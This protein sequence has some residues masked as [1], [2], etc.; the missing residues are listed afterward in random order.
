MAGRSGYCTV[1]YSDGMREALQLSLEQISYYDHLA[2]SSTSRP[3]VHAYRI[4]NIRGAQYHVLSRIADAGLDFTRRTNFIAHHLAFQS[5]ELPASDA[6]EALTPP[7]I[8]LY[9]D[10]WR[11]EWSQ[12]PRL[13]KNEQW[14][15]LFTLGSNTCN[16]AREWKE[17]TDDAANGLAP[18][19]STDREYFLSDEL[20]SK[21]ILKL[22]A[23]TSALAVARPGGGGPWQ[24]TFS[25]FLQERDVPSDFRWRVV[26][27]KSPAY[28]RLVARDALIKPLKSLRPNSPDPL[29]VA[30]ARSGPQPLRITGQPEDKKLTAR[31][32]LILQVKCEGVP[33]PK[34]YQWYSCTRTGSRQ[35]LRDAQGPGLQ[36]EKPPGGVSRYQVVITDAQGKSVESR[37]AV[38]ETELDRTPVQGG[39]PRKL[40]LSQRGASPVETGDDAV[41]VRPKQLVEVDDEEESPDAF[42]LEEEEGSPGNRWL[43]TAIGV[44]LVIFLAL[45][46]F[47]VKGFFP[48]PSHST[49]PAPAAVSATNSPDGNATNQAPQNATQKPPDK[50]ASSQPT[51]PPPIVLQKSNPKVALIIL[52]AGL[53]TDSIDALKN[54]MKVIS[55]D[56]QN[57]D[58]HLA[59]LKNDLE[60]EKEKKGKDYNTDRVKGLA[61]Q[62]SDIKLHLQEYR[63]Q[64]YNLKGQLSRLTRRYDEQK[65]YADEELKNRLGG[66]FDFIL[67]Q[68]LYMQAGELT[69]LQPF[70]SSSA[71]ALDLPGDHFHFQLT[72]TTNDLYG[73]EGVVPLKNKLAEPFLMTLAITNSQD[74]AAAARLLILPG[75]NTP[76]NATWNINGEIN[77]A[78]SKFM[79]ELANFNGVGKYDLNCE[80]YCANGVG[81]GVVAFTNFPFVPGQD[82]WFAGLAEKVA[83]W[84]QA[85]IAV[86][87]IMALNKEAVSAP[88]TN[89]WD[90]LDLIC[91]NLTKV[92]LPYRFKENPENAREQVLLDAPK[93]RAE[94]IQSALSSENVKSLKI[95]LAEEPNLPSLNAAKRQLQFFLPNG[96]NLD[97]ALLSGRIVRKDNGQQLARLVLNKN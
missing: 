5:H 61:N 6:S 24:Q 67:G 42:Q 85:V 38:V 16:P 87:A 10:G 34:L 15:N 48:A 41:K 89:V 91:Q 90:D 96:S 69:R 56:I 23:E 40:T 65:S 94:E 30:Y 21:Q 64:E 17:V 55:T 59:Q 32:P 33:P 39:S 7:L 86:T 72:A 29:A 1:A 35:I 44:F 79:E 25:T 54:Q 51:T 31:Q 71:G 80:F 58:D 2:G 22:F 36:L 78:K 81:Q 92:P 60:T 83:H 20:D 75:T 62:I 13:L 70:Q 4:L 3:L 27:S 82:Y 95:F 19:D 12:E 46:V 76:V 52:D 11:D 53:D 88:T 18:W 49:S 57:S 26:R 73:I 45:A 14:G 8:F 9:W 66:L 43:W 37:V 74:S 28:E 50:S 47:L 97:P 68:P 77:V 93:D 84:K 63:G